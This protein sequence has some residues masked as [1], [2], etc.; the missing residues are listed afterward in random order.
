MKKTIEDINNSDWPDILKRRM[1]EAAR[2]M[3]AGNL[4]DLSDEGPMK[5]DLHKQTPTKIGTNPKVPNNR[6]WGLPHVRN[7]IKRTSLWGLH[8]NRYLPRKRNR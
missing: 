6:E 3:A 7:L 5:D 8:E 1:I 4:R 2:E